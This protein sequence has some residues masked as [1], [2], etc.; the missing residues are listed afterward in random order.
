MSSDRGMKKYAPFASLIEQ[1]MCLNEMRYKKNKI[2]KPKIA[3]ERA[4]KINK[5][6]V[7]YHKE[8]VTITYFYDGYLYDLK[9]VIEKVDKNKKRI[10]IND[11]IIP[12]SEIID[13]NS[14][15]INDFDFD[16]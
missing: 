16:I 9:G 4:D 14:N 2:D 12:F 3:S 7:N 11:A 6:L 8:E 15:E 13:I 1:S 10:I 5:I